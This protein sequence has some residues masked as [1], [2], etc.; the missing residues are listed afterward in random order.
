MPNKGF[1]H[2]QESRDKISKHNAHNRSWL[3][4]KRPDISGENNPAS[5][6]EIKEK[7]SKARKGQHNS[8]KTQFKKGHNRGKPSW[9][10]G[11]PHTLEWKMSHS[12]KMIGEGNSNW[13]GGITIDPYPPKF[14]VALKL[15]IR[16][17]DNFICVLCSRTEREELEEFNRVLSVNHIDFNKNNCEE[18]NLNT[19]CLR[20]NVKINRER[21]YWTDYFNQ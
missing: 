6:P 17:R 9:N 13:Q 4:K 3:G 14:N 2:T 18:K 12:K 15:S 7:I 5:R 16:T 19:L 8:P 11:I 10:K 21:E 1:K 20:C